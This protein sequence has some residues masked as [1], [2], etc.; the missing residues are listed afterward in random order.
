MKLS[1][2]IHA[3]HCALREQMRLV[4]C[5]A[6]VQR[7]LGCSYNRAALVLGFL[8]DAKVIG[9]TNDHGERRWLMDSELA[10]TTLREAI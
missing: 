5:I 1:D 6:Y 4:G 3:G 9:T 7:K 10:V 2:Q 8:E